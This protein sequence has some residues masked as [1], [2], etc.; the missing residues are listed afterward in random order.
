MD[1]KQN[2]NQF[3]MGKT[4]SGHWRKSPLKTG[5][6]KRLVVDHT[7]TDDALG[8]RALPGNWWNGWR[9]MPGRMTTSC[10]ATCPY[11]KKV[12]SEAAFEDVCMWAAKDKL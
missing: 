6:N 2:G 4:Q 5:G 10:R 9:T 12:L 7:Y 1:F 8:A 3:Y 11:A